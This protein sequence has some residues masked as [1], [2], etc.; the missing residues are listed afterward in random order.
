MYDGIK[1]DN[2]LGPHFSANKTKCILYNVV[3]CLRRLSMVLCF[4]HF[5]DVGNEAVFNAMLGIQTVYLVYII[6]SAPHVDTYFNV[7]EIFN[8]ISIILLVYSFKGFTP[9]S[10]LDQSA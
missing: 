10:M 1:T 6:Y 8:E 2:Y 4:L 9:N 7:L 3:F 5:R